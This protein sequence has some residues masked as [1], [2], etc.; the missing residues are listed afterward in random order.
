MSTQLDKIFRLLRLAALICGT[1][2]TL[3]LT[4]AGVK[5]TDPEG[6]LLIVGL[7]SIGAS[8]IAP[9]WCLYRGRFPLWP[10]ALALAAV[11]IGLMELNSWNGRVVQKG[12]F[13]PHI[14]DFWFLIL[15]ALPGISIVAWKRLTREST[16]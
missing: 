12:E 15:Y 7:G 3:W 4:W 1:V 5:D 2:F 16:L 8:I 11:L 6:R 14:Y 10:F 9:F 13:Q